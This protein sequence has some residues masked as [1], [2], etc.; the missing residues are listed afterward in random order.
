LAAELVARLRTGDV[1]VDVGA[2]IGMY[3]LI[4]AH[5]VGPTGH[6]FAIEPQP[7]C[8]EPL[9]AN[10]SL[11]AF[12]NVVPVATAVGDVDGEIGFSANERSMGG[13]IS[14]TA[15][16]TVPILRLDTFARERSLP[17]I[18]VLKLDAAGNE[19]PA[20]LGATEMLTKHRIRAVLCKL[21]HPAVVMDRFGYES[22]L[23]VERLQRAGYKTYALP[24]S[25][26]PRRAISDG[27]NIAELFDPLTY[28][29]TL[30][31]VPAD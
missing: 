8:L 1:F 3:T 26:E 13:M 10:V 5:V 30:L 11:N 28:S 19:H 18:D 23:I 2:H 14:R 29:R 27:S 22:S 21:Y 15:E 17:A 7:A 12:T 9:R 24:T 25:A 20:L 4:A 6:V 16:A 31:A